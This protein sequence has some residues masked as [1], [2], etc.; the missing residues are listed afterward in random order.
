VF[1]YFH[2]F[3]YGNGLLKWNGILSI[4]F[5]SPYYLTSSKPASAFSQPEAFLRER[6][7]DRVLSS[8]PMLIVMIFLRV[9]VFDSLSWFL[10]TTYRTEYIVFASFPVYISDLM[11]YRTGRKSLGMNKGRDHGINQEHH[12]RRRLVILFLSLS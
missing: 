1:Y 11:G 10:S 4:Y 9:S 3:F 8:I 6:E 7:R 5:L 12:H 2:F